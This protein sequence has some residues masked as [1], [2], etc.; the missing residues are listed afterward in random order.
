MT[1]KARAP[2]KPRCGAK[3]RRGGKCTQPR[4]HRTDHPGF[5]NCWLHGGRSPNGAK[6]AQRE[7][8]EVELA[9]LG[10][11]R[12]NGD[13]FALL[14]KAVQ[15]ADG[16]LEAASVIVQEADRLLDTKAAD[17][18]PRVEL[19][20]AV[21][22]Y[23][24]AIRTA[25]RT[26]KAAVDADVA[27]RLAALDERAASLLMRFVAE[28]LDRFVPKTRRTEGEAWAAARLGELATEYERPGAMH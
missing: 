3:T 14:A 8:A 25:F 6:H 1:T 11:P 19:G 28:L 21:E 22:I 16:H 18:T 13:P 24:Q 17:K 20:A 9:R 4:G 26:A 23:E 2:R 5:G 27:D 15:H 10:V 12:G 7:Q